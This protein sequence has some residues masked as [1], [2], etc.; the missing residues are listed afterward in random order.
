[1]I[2]KRKHPRIKVNS[3]VWYN[4]KPRAH[5]ANIS[6]GGICIFDIKPL[7]NKKND[8]LISLCFPNEKKTFKIKATGKQ[9]WNH[10]FHPKIFESGIQFMR[11]SEIDKEILE[12]YI[13]KML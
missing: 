8:F 7:N 2:D 10:F 11:I 4:N 6:I 5:S 1:M 3:V 9:V 12:S 13:K